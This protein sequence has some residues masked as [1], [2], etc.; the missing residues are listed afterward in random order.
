[1]E[2]L[3]TIIRT[4]RAQIMLRVKPNSAY[5]LGTRSMKPLSKKFGYDRGTPIDRYFIEKFLKQH[6]KDIHGHCL[7]VVDDKYIKM[8]GGDRVTKTDVVDNDG[9]SKTA[10]I[11]DDLTELK[12]V[13]DNTFD[14]LVITHTMG[15][16]PEF[17]K[18]VETCYRV[19]K[20]GGVLLVT[21]AA[22]SPL[23]EN[24][25]TYWRCT[26]FGAEYMFG[27]VFK[28]DKLKITPYGNVL[29]SQCFWVGMAQEEL[30]KKELDYDDPH[31]PCVIGIRAQK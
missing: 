2:K 22:F 17:Q 28:H 18:A 3:L 26:Q 21:S 12:T 20:P 1:M 19:L 25:K 31:Y 7:E 29:T 11:V 14:C 27:K 13:K 5:F 4:V 24:E 15:M 16:I 23:V 8:F 6:E 9:K 30:T 10:T